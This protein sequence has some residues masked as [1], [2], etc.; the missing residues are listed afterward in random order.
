MTGVRIDV[1]S[2]LG[3]QGVELD[4]WRAL[5]DLV[6]PPD[7]PRP[8]TGMEWAP[9]QDDDHI[10]RVW[11]DDQLRAC[12]WVTWRVVSIDDREGPVAGIRGVM[13]HPDARRRG[14]GR[15]AMLHAQAVIDWGP[16]TEMALLFSSEMG[17]AFY[18]SLGWVEVGVPVLIEQAAGRIDY[19]ALHPEAPVMAR[20]R[21]G[22]VLPSKAIEVHGLPW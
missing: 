2:S 7:R 14:Y 17:V 21:P 22:A 4:E 15:A 9:R 18:R 10:V 5:G 13:T 16:P 20:L 1:R 3:L 19:M 8:A 6:H 12:A 11:D